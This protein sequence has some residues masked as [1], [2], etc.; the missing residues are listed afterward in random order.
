LSRYKVSEV[1]GKL[2]E[3]RES[4]VPLSDQELVFRRVLCSVTAGRKVG[5][6][7]PA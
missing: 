7:N 4:L 2:E 6:L 1:K 3:D 5:S